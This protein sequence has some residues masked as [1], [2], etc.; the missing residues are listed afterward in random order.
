MIKE[1]IYKFFE[2]ENKT[3]EYREQ[4]EINFAP[5]YI[6]SCKRQIYYKKLKIEPSNPL[7]THAYIK[8][9]LGDATHE[10]IQSIFFNMG[11][12]QEGED[13]KEI[14]WQGLKW[15][16]R[17]DAK[18]K[19]DDN[20]YI[21]EIKS[22]YFSGNK[23]VEHEA[24]EEH[25]LQ[26][27]LYMIFE[28]IERGI[29]LYIGRDNGMMYEYHYSLES[30]KEKYK[31]FFT[32]KLKELKELKGKIENKILPDRDFEIV[33]KNNNGNITDYFQKNNEK[34]KSDW[35]CSYCQYKDLCWQDILK[36]IKNHN[37]YIG[38]KFE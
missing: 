17:I 8:F 13:W 29:I 37:F 14:V 21:C 30:L 6:N 16:Y 11:Y 18:L 19:I 36:E 26:L 23:A 7:E 2:S 27:M 22:S 38:G 35:Q 24:K 9:A 20:I 5:S 12:W 28:N 32:E 4:Q 3:K 33:L 31:D 10:K 25:I 1:A 15:I 34:Y